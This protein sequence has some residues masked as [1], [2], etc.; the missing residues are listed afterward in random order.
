LT[1]TKITYRDFLL[2]LTS[3]QKVFAAHLFLRTFATNNGKFNRLLFFFVWFEFFCIF[4]VIRKIMVN[5]FFE[6]LLNVLPKQGDVH[7][8]K[9][10]VN[11]VIARNE[12]IS[13]T[14]SRDGARPVSTFLAMTV[15][16]APFAEAN[17]FV[18]VFPLFPKRNSASKN[19]LTEIR[20]ITYTGKDKCSP[21]ESENT[22]EEYISGGI[23]IKGI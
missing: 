11:T 9:L 14:R 13:D 3:S 4:A 19:E 22:L 21:V 15:R 5:S 1:K 7:S 16:A 17:V 18:I 12:A 23:I 8:S 6:A 20:I 10:S 2:T